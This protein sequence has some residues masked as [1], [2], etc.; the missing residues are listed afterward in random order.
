MRYLMFG[1][2]LIHTDK[3]DVAWYHSQTF[4]LSIFDCLQYAENSGGSLG[5]FILLRT[6]IVRVVNMKYELHKQ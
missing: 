2:V 1:T 5:T 4:P 6:T 3:I